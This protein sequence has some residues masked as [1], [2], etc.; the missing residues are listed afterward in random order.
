MKIKIRKAK[1]SD[2]SEMS[3]LRIENLRQELSKYYD[4][5][6]I[7][8]SVARNTEEKIIEKMKSWSM[9][10]AV[11][12]HGKIVGT[13]GFYDK[14]FLG[15]LYVGLDCLGLGVGR[16]LVLHIENFLKKNSEE[17]VRLY[18]TVNACGFYKKLGYKIV[19]K[20]KGFVGV[21]ECMVT[22]MDKKL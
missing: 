10:V 17:K 11:D 6:Y 5:L 19:N 13:A 15:G 12:G 16:K 3:K 7:N 1:D 20:R 2:A 4:E 21:A 8:E 14:N 22:E 18:S 9:F